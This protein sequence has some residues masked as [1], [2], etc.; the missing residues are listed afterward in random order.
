MTLLGSIVDINSGHSVFGL[1]TNDLQVLD[2]LSDFWMSNYTLCEEAKVEPSPVAEL[3][4]EKW[5]CNNTQRLGDPIDTIKSALSMP[6]VRYPV[7][8]TLPYLW[9]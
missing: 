6:V 3:G 4:P 2:M 5:L 1:V 7:A 8:D 9:R